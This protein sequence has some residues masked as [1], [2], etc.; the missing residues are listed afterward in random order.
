M[1]K[2]I[3]QIPAKSKQAFQQFKFENAGQIQSDSFIGQWLAMLVAL[4]ETK[5]IVEFG[6]WSGAGSSTIIAKSVEV[7][8]DPET[9]VIGF[10]LNERMARESKRRLKRFAFFSV[11]HGSVV[12][13][14]ELETSNLSI[15]EQSW[16]EQDIA[17]L[18][19]SPYVLDVLPRSIDLCL[20]DGGEFSTYSEWLKIRDRVSQWLVLDDTKVRKNKKVLEEA[21]QCG[22]WLLISTSDERNGTAVL[23][24]IK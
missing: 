5:S 12:T 17:W 13:P 23:K 9:F 3:L 2:Q 4:P 6:T 22:D 20:L 1:L 16:L 10:E 19:E 21:L 18:S 14:D 11:I 24:R 15:E 8:N 7:K